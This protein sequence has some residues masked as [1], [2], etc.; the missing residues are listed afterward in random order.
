M[1]HRIDQSTTSCFDCIYSY[2]YTITACSHTICINCL[3]AAV[4][5]KIRLQLETFVC[6]RC[7][8]KEESTQVNQPQ[9]QEHIQTLEL[10]L[11]RLTEENIH[12]NQQLTQQQHTSSN[13]INIG[14]STNVKIQVLSEQVKKLSIDN[15]NWEKQAHNNELLA[16]EIQK[17]KEDLI[18]HN[19]QLAQ[20]MYLI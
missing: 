1:A 3:H 20:C 2:H 10:Q 15:A 17:E 5:E 7:P 6:P 4:A 8:D 13:L 19:E 14:A 16:K 12:L 18:R 11:K 9:Q